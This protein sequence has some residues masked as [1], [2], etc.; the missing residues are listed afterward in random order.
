MPDKPFEQDI[1]D[2]CDPLGKKIGREFFES[3]LGWH[4]KSDVEAYREGD[5]EFEE[6]MVET[7]VRYNGDN[8]NADKIWSGKY[9]SLH[10]PER[11]AKMDFSKI[12]RYI[13]I[14]GETLNQ[15]AVTTG[16][17]VLDC[18]R[19][20]RKWCRSKSGKWIEE[21]LPDPQLGRWSFYEKRNGVWEPVFI[22]YRA[23]YSPIRVE[24]ERRKDS[25]LVQS[26]WP[27]FD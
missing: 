23:F 9:S 15:V 14:N 24:M 13:A 11:K 1:Y 10:L 26:R 7:E 19:T 27:V 21:D 12:A 5:L 22:E 17:D 6:G 18:G 20:V 16:Q 2:E 8:N 4:F 25:L 3:Y